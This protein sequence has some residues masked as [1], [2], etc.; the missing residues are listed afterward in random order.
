MHERLVP[1]HLL[2]FFRQFLYGDHSHLADSLIDSQY[3]E[4]VP[5]PEAF[6]FAG[7]HGVRNFFSIIIKGLGIFLGIALLS[8]GGFI[9]IE[10]LQAPGTIN[11]PI[12]VFSVAGILVGSI[13]LWLVFKKK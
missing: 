12:L 2:P 7:E 3:Q 5:N 11:I 6:N 13:M 8:L 9:G 10:D 1:V 4:H